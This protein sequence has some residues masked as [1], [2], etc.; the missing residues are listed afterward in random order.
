LQAKVSNFE[1]ERLKIERE[2]MQI[3]SQI[4]WFQAQTERSYKN[5]SIEVNR[6]KVQIELEQLNDGNPYNDEVK[7]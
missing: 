7:Y 3:D 1:E 5:D 4:R 6:Q 2:R